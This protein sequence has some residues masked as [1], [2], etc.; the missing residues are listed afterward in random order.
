MSEIFKILGELTLNIIGSAIVVC[1]TTL[2]YKNNLA[3]KLN[4]LTSAK[5]SCGKINDSLKGAKATLIEARK[6]L[7]VIPDPALEAKFLEFMQSIETSID[8]GASELSYF[9]GSLDT[10]ERAGD[11]LE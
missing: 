8:S 7:S 5:T 10:I 3:E 6:S 2:Y 1:V 11:E 9:T 4:K